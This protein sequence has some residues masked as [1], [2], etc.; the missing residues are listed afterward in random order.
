MGK[1]RAA[2]W[3]RRDVGVWV[4]GGA[5]ASAILGVVA[6]AAHHGAPPRVT[7][8]P[9]T[10]AA[11]ADGTALVIERVDRAESDGDGGSCH[12]RLPRRFARTGPSW[13][14][15]RSPESGAP[16]IALAWCIDA[17]GATE[18]VDGDPR[19]AR[20]HRGARAAPMKP[21]DGP[22]ADR[23]GGLLPDP[24]GGCAHRSRDVRDQPQRWHRHR[25]APGARGRGRRSGDR[26][27][28]LVDRGEG[29]GRT[30]R[31][32]ERSGQAS[33]GVAP[34]RPTSLTACSPVAPVR[35]RSPAVERRDDQ[36]GAPLAWL[37]ARGGTRWSP[38]PRQRGRAVVTGDTSSWRT[39]AGSAWSLATGAPHRDDVRGGATCGRRDRCARLRSMTTRHRATPPALAVTYVDEDFAV[40]SDCCDPAPPRAARRGRVRRSPWGRNA[41]IAAARRPRS[42]RRQPGRRVVAVLGASSRYDLI[43]RHG[44]NRG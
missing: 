14:V 25:P 40:P 8:T 32:L 39:R 13:P 9:L 34:S 3:Y 30:P 10:G 31:R 1:H 24:A 27:A 41:A 18:L 2:A 20:R 26:R 28:A 16:R 21:A 17:T 12:D 38:D 19:P 29:T 11:L 23:A 33:A 22:L 35:R 36:R 15:A 43:R 44:A 4:I 5:I 42:D 37:P 6:Y 7:T